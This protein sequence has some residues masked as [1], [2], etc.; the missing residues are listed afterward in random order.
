M[1]NIK[2]THKLLAG[3]VIIS[4]LSVFISFLGIAGLQKTKENSTAVEQVNDKEESILVTYIKTQKMT[5]D[6]SQI[7]NPNNSDKIES[8]LANLQQQSDALNEDIAALK[9]MLTSSEEKLIIGEIESIQAEY[10]LISAEISKALMQKDYIKANELYNKE[11]TEVWNKAELTL[12]NAFAYFMEQRD[13]TEA[14]HQNLIESRTTQIIVVS[15]IVILLSILTTLIIAIPFKKRINEIV[16]FVNE[17]E[18]GDVS[19]HLKITSKDEMGQLSQAINKAVDG[20]KFLVDKISGSTVEISGGAEGLTA[21]SE[22]ISAN[23]DII[24]ESIEETS[25][26][27]NYISGSTGEISIA[28]TDIEEAVNNLSVK[29]QDGESRSIEIMQ[30]ANG[31]KE[32][33]FESTKTANEIY[34]D[35]Q[36]KIFNAIEK[37]KV[38]DQ[39][40][41]LANTIGEIAGQTNLLSLNASIEAARAGEAGKGFAVVAN[42]VRN[43]ADQ[44]NKSAQDIR[45]VIE[46]IE[47]AFKEMT[48]LSLEIM[49][50]ID[51]KVKPD[52]NLLV[53]IGENYLLDA[54]FVNN[55]SNEIAKSSHGITKAISDLN[56]AI[57]TV[58]ST[59]QQTAASADTILHSI[60]LT[61]DATREIVETAQ[62]Q[63]ELAENLKTISNSFK[64]K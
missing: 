34:E 40:G 6:L 42:E 44:S 25:T 19:K 8:Q 7:I 26:A 12:E 3:F 10:R 4:L 41:L 20:T 43:L 57:Q 18:N 21:T 61:A 23:M 49:E 59:T 60:N 32:R 55:M 2:I 62:V 15:A 39:I 64:T 54:Q 14:E 31:V 52:Y 13:I 46:E 33:A 17:I 5:K 50:F 27:I 36:V 30:R 58:S 1:K 11:L 35:K 9:K 53:E 56:M 28:S 38:V 47:Y 22:E 37:A 16:A 51:G 45:L 48:E 63:T 24:R 29:A